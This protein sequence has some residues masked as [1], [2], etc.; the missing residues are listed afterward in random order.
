MGRVLWFS[1]ILRPKFG[2]YL[3]VVSI[4]S[5][6]DFCVC[7]YIDDEFVFLSDKNSAI[8]LE[9]NSIFYI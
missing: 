6:L 5:F 7:E 2:Q 4:N 8:S 1:V 3:A 9:M